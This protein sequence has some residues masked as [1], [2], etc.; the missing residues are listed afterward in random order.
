MGDGS[1]RH[2]WPED[3]GPRSEAFR[4]GYSCCIEWL[5]DG[6]QGVSEYSHE[7]RQ[8]FALTDTIQPHAKS[9]DFRTVRH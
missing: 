3:Y 5:V 9:T 1:I 7:N 8:A 2:P 4:Q 6:A